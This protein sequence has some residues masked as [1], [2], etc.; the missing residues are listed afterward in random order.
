M[1]TKTELVNE[2][3][4]LTGE[5]KKT[6]KVMTKEQLII[7]LHETGKRKDL[8]PIHGKHVWLVN[9][10][11]RRRSS[12]RSNRIS[13]KRNKHV[14]LVSPRSRPKRRRKSPKRSKSPKRRLEMGRK[15][16]N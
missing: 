10:P 2:L 16:V 8:R 12:R 11:K 13:P 6:F 9:P 5:Q 7:L 1:T 4:R 3:S 14:R 15:L